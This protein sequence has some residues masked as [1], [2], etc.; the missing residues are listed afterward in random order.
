MIYALKTIIH[1]FFR[2]FLYVF[3]VFPILHTLGLSKLLDALWKRLKLQINVKAM[4][5]KHLNGLIKLQNFYWDSITSNIFVRS[6]QAFYIG[7]D[8][9][10]WNRKKLWRWGSSLEDRTNTYGFKLLD[11][12]NHLKWDN[13]CLYQWK[14]ESQLKM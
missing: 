2:T 9:C 12:H 8:Y 13:F 10:I 6:I 5:K 4:F 11:F 14:V 7:C 3:W 1:V